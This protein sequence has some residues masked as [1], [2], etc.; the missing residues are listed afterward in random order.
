MW[1]S[2]LLLVLARCTD[3]VEEKCIAVLSAADSVDGLDIVG[4]AIWRELLTVLQTDF[5]DLFSCVDS[6]IFHHVRG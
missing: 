4:N 2:L 6:N 1:L 3:F 5:P